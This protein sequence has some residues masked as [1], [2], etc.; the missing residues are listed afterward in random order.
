M[1]FQHHSHSRLWGEQEMLIVAW[2]E[3]G[4]LLAEAFYSD[5]SIGVD[6]YR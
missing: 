3:D 6:S 4:S 5:F 1:T 2:V